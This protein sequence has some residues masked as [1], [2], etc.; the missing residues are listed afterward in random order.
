MP[1][2]YDYLAKVPGKCVILRIAAL[3]LLTVGLIDITVAEVFQYIRPDL[4]PGLLR[5]VLFANSPLGLVLIGLAFLLWG[6]QHL[7]LVGAIGAD[8]AGKQ[9]ELLEQ[10][11]NAAGEGSPRGAE[12]IPVAHPVPILSPIESTQQPYAASS[13]ATLDLTPLVTL[14]TEIRNTLLMSETERAALAASRHET[15]R[16]NIRRSIDEALANGNYAEAETRI[17][18]LRSLAPH[19]PELLALADV[20]EQ[21]LNDLRSTA[22]RSEIDAASAQVQ[23]LMS[24]SAWQQAEEIVSNLRHKFGDESTI[25]QLADYI[26]RERDALEKEHYTRLTG[27]LKDATER[28]DWRRALDLSEELIRR[29]PHERKIEKLARDQLATITEN[30]QAQERREEEALFTDLLH[31]QRYNDAAAVARRVMAK[32]PGS[33]AA[34]ELSKLLPKVEEL[35]RQENARRAPPTA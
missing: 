8:R 23:H 3:F 32:Y 22:A 17:A 6:A 27:D 35:I 25:V 11:K 29:F 13:A 19:D 10:L 16:E 33:P 2:P 1:V 12:Q 7:L 5:N 30:A 31:R 14:L 4:L 15:S 28:R 9:I 18:D 21:Q 24:I 26:H 34:T 20:L